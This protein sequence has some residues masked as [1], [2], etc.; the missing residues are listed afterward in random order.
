MGLIVYSY[1]GMSG[2]FGIDLNIIETNF[3]NLAIL[4]A[5]ILNLGSDFVSKSLTARTQSIV[6]TFQVAGKKSL[7]VNRLQIRQEKLLYKVAVLDSLREIIVNEGIKIIHTKTERQFSTILR[8]LLRA[9]DENIG[10]SV[11]SSTATSVGRL[12]ST[13]VFIYTCSL[14][15]PLLSGSFKRKKVLDVVSKVENSKLAI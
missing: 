5:G 4:G 9:I 11:L 10:S 13:S 7:L 12:W 3:V 6:N 2:S 15:D 14:L 1:Y 8:M